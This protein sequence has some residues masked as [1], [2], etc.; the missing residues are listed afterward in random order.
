[1]SSE[2]I[3]GGGPFKAAIGRHE[4]LAVDDLKAARRAW[5]LYCA[6]DDRL[7]KRFADM[8]LRTSRLVAKA[9]LEDLQSEGYSGADLAILGVR[10][11]LGEFYGLLLAGALVVRGERALVMAKTD[12]LMPDGTLVAEGDVTFMDLGLAA[13]LYAASMVEP[14]RASS[15]AL[16]EI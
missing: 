2:I 12:L 7:C 16:G 4:P 15:L 6:G 1:M 11:R 9:R 13:A 14:A 10:D 3:P 5:A 8:V